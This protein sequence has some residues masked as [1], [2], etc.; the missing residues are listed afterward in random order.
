MLGLLSNAW[1][2]VRVSRKISVK[3]PKPIAA[4]NQRTFRIDPHRTEANRDL[5]RTYIRPTEGNR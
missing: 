1:S 5:A 4:T 3:T 2:E